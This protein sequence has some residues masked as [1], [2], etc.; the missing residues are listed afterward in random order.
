[1]SIIGLGSSAPFQLASGNDGRFV[2]FRVELG[3]IQSL[4][5]FLLQ[6]F[7]S[8]FHPLQSPEDEGN[9]FPR[10]IDAFDAGSRRIAQVPLQGGEQ[11]HRVFLTVGPGDLALFLAEQQRF[12]GVGGDSEACVR[13]RM[14][15]SLRT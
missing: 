15:S 11:V 4:P 1:M 2:V 6:Q 7:D 5:G 12:F 8:R 10:F 13:R 14:Y 3:D 9:L